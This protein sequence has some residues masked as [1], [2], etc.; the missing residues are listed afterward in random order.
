MKIVI[1]GAGSAGLGVAEQLHRYKM[2]LGMSDIEAYKSFFVLD[3][4]GI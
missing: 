3:D 2:S 4:K 1:C